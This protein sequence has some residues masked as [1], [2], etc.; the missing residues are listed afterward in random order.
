M[1]AQLACQCLII[2]HHVSSLKKI[3]YIY[4]M[5]TFSHSVLLASVFV[6]RKLNVSS[7]T[8]QSMLLTQNTRSLSTR[9]LLCHKREWNL[10]P[11]GSIF[12]LSFYFYLSS[13]SNRNKQI[14]FL[15]NIIY[16]GNICLVVQSA[17]YLLG[18]APAAYREV[19]QTCPP[20]GRALSGQ[21][22]VGLFTDQEWKPQRAF[23][24]REWEN[25]TGFA[26]GIIIEKDIHLCRHYLPI[27]TNR[28]KT[29][30]SG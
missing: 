18:L 22:A 5:I 28:P 2:Q 25:D 19:I 1:C 8:C 6:T 10:L 7:A 26:N 13:R 23:S 17:L 29:S 3:L 9:P 14:T 27:Q 30:L 12:L 16:F 11:K 24:C 4:W 15:F 20:V 21:R